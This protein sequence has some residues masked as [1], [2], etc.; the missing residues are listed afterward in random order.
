MFSLASRRFNDFLTCFTLWE[1]DG[2][3]NYTLAKISIR[4]TEKALNLHQ[5]APKYSPECVVQIFINIQ[6]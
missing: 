5:I 2:S 3:L 4:H 6:G 1:A